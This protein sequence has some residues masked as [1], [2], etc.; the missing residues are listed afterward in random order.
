MANLASYF[1]GLDLDTGGGT[2]RVLQVTLRGEGSGGSLSVYTAPVALAENTA[3][4]TV[5]GLAVFGMVF[6][7]ATWDRMP[8]SSADGVVVDLGTNNNVTIDSGTVTADTE[9]LAAAVLADNTANPTITGIASYPH[10]FDGTNWDRARGDETDGL[11]VN[12]GTNNDVTTEL[13]TAAGI[14][15][16]LANPTTPAIASHLVGYDRVNDDWTRIAGL[17]DGEV[18]GALNA[19]FLQFGTDGA[20]YQAI[21]TDAS[22]HLQVDVLTGGGTDTPTN[23][24]FDSQIEV[25]LA[26][27]GSADID[28]AALENKKLSWVDVWASVPFLAEIKTVDNG[29]PSGTKGVT[30]GAAH[31]PAQYIPTHRDYIQTGSTAGVD[32][33]RVTA[34]NLDDDNAADIYVT[35][36]Y[37][38]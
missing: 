24:N 4:P 17:V 6:D 19:G 5:G 9:L 30:G 22:G 1:T 32:A 33:F 37:E 15:D 10:W 16:S 25:G 13:P 27:A 28:S 34:V 18:V 23:P 36:H 26:A 2:E 20:N 3:N 31:M 21:L 14:S 11:I 35:F 8:G 12:L 38:D 29:T 7:G